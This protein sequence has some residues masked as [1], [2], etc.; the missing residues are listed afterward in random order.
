MCVITG[1]YSGLGGLLVE[2]PASA[3]GRGY[4]GNWCPEGWNQ[5]LSRVG[6]KCESTAERYLAT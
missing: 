4:V 6:W 3:G 1:E 5:V 2:P